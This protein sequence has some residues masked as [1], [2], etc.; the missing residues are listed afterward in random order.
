MISTRGVLLYVNRAAELLFEL[1][2]NNDIG[3]SIGLFDWLFYA[4]EDARSLDIHQLLE[5]ALFKCKS[6]NHKVVS[7]KVTD[8]KPKQW[9]LL[10]ISPLLGD[11]ERGEYYVLSFTDVNTLI[12]EAEQLK[13]QATA[14]SV[15]DE[16][17]L[18]LDKTMNVLSVNDAFVIPFKNYA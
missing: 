11:K 2:K 10:N 15:T 18:V 12:T 4:K 9:M 13:W 3:Q 17:V 6:L 5:L 1:D 7:V 16:S 8:K 14:F